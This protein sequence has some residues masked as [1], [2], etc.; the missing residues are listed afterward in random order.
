MI[1]LCR[2]MACVTIK[3][4]FINLRWRQGTS[5]HTILAN[6]RRQLVSYGRWALMRDADAVQF[7]E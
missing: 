1:A 3:G 5:Y 2:R 7:K 4:L 6:N